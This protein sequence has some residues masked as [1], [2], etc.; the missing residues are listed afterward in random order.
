MDRDIVGV[1]PENNP[2]SIVQPHEFSNLLAV[3]LQGSEC[4]LKLP[5]EDQQTGGEC[6]EY[7]RNL[8]LLKQFLPYIH[9]RLLA[10]RARLENTQT[11]LV[12][13]SAWARSFS[14]GSR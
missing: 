10:E 4:L 5:E 12:A 13:A 9:G 2:C 6:A 8:E 1:Q 11:H 14:Q 3:V 7:R